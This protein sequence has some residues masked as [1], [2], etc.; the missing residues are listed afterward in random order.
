MHCHQQTW[1]GLEDILREIARSKLTIKTIVFRCL[2]GS[3]NWPAIDQ[4]CDD[5][6]SL[7]MMHIEC[8]TRLDLF[9][10]HGSTLFGP[11]TAAIIE[12]RIKRMENS[13][14]MISARGRLKILRLDPA[15][16][17]C[18]YESRYPTILYRTM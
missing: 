9:P 13:L 3:A 14:P 4:V 7:W 10:E 18:D 6:Q 12:Y 1:F 15:L 17:F 11:L 5:S 2:P 8:Y 16:G